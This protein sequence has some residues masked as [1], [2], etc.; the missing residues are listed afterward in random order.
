MSKK[1]RKKSKSKTRLRRLASSHGIDHTGFGSTPSIL[2]LGVARRPYESSTF[3]DDPSVPSTSRTLDGHFSRTIANTAG[4]LT[5]TSPT[6]HQSHYRGVADQIERNPK[7]KSA[8]NR[9]QAHRDQ[10]CR[11]NRLQTIGNTCFIN[12]AIRC[13]E[14]ITRKVV[15]HN[16]NHRNRDDN[17]ARVSAAAEVAPAAKLDRV[18]SRRRTPI[19]DRAA[20][21]QRQPQFVKL[22]T[23]GTVRVYERAARNTSGVQRAPR[24]S[25]G[26]IHP[27]RPAARVE[28]GRE[29]AGQRPRR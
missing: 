29:L 1:R 21:V 3:R 24:S 2:E 26:Y 28:S 20:H 8:R 11:L 9:L 6:A 18:N 10:R 25:Q 19:A 4:D 13:L 5:S 7:H 14:Y 12:S 15:L 27:A 17:N 23:G 16:D 22:V